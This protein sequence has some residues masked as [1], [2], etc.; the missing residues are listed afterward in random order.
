MARITLEG[1][2]RGPATME[3]Y[4]ALEMGDILYFPT[5]P[6][7]FADEDRDFLLTQRQVD[8]SY[9]K[10]I[11]YRPAEDR[12]KGVDAQSDSDRGRTH[13]VMRRYSRSAIAFMTAF[14]PRY[15]GAWKIDYASFRPH[16][17]QGRKIARRARNDLIHVDSFPTRP[18]YGDRLLRI[19]TNINPERPRIW[20]TSDNFAALARVYAR[21]AGLPFTRGG[22]WSGL[23]GGATRMLSRLGLP[24]VHRP[25]YD[26]FMLRFHNFLKENEE[27]QYNCRKDSWTFPPGSAWMVFTDAASHACLSGQYA[28]EQT[29]IVSHDSL[30]YPDE[31]PLSILE[32]MTG[33]ALAPAR[34]TA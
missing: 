9:H 22:R 1:V 23:R 32:Q 27:F 30:A 15:A 18:S 21:R 16:E 34:R 28:L 11:S 20:A 14:L 10:N 33:F 5:T 13:E 25:E 3:Q 6:F 31:S 7:L 2:E 12:L 8:A 24:I 29:F 4:H 17:E 26:R 19:F